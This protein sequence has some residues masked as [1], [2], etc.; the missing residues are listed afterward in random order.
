MNVSRVRR[1]QTAKIRQ[2][3]K[4]AVSNMA[5]CNKTQFLKN[6][7]KHKMNSGLG[8]ELSSGVSLEYMILIFSFL[9]KILK[10]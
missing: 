2:I 10:R 7:S 1:L 4:T 5:V 3:S 6:H 9:S 8:K